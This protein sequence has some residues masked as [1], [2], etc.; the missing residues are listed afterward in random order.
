MNAE[1]KSYVESLEPSFQRLIA[2]I[3]VS[4]ATLP[5]DL[6][7]SGVYLFSE[8]DDHLYAGRTDRMRQRLQ[9]HCRPASPQNA[10]SF[11]FRLAQEI[12]GI[13]T[14]KYSPDGSRTKLERHPGFQPEFTRQ[15]QRIRT[16]DLRYVPEPD[17]MRQALLEMYVAV[18]LKTKHNDFE[19]H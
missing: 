12:T 8:G 16:M 4:V 9:E 11:A 17:P 13:R 19:N 18:S 1:F 3:P 14:I 7:Q 10:A 15:K 6:P 5:L 2:M